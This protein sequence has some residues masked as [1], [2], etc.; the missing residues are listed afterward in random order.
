MISQPNT[1]RLRFQLIAVTFARLIISTAQRMFYPFLPEISRGLGVSQDTLRWMLSLRGAYGMSAPLFGPIV[2][3]FGRRNAMLIG[4]AIFCASLALV[5]IYPNVITVFLCI[6]LII[7]SKFVF[8]PAI[9]AYL[10]DH[11]P[12]EKRGLVIA[13]TEFG[14]AGA[15][16][17]GV[18]VVGF[19]IARGDWRAP[20]WPLAGLGVLAAIWMAAAI[21][22]DPPHPGHTGLNG[23]DRWLK[24]IRNPVVLAALITNML[25]AA[26]NEIINIVYGSWMEQTFNLRVVQLGLS[27]AVIGVA[28]LIAEGGVAV[29]S[30]RLGKRQTLILGLVVS[31]V[32][33]FLLPFGS[34][35]LEWA[36]AGIFAVYLAFEFAIVASIPLI[37]ELMPEYRNTVMSTSIAA[38]AAGRMIGSLLGGFVFQ[39]GFLW[40]GVVAGILTMIGIPLILWVVRE[41]Q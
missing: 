33:Y 21:P 1:S 5:A 35:S 36:L 40:N 24:V 27:V 2:D 30:D 25:S 23:L 7:T 20:F 3:R 22:P 4:M 18:P 15:V 8:D 14:W 28:E 16:L 19:L 6:L 12:Y 41:R 13:L 26:S 37:S 39:F 31:A 17:I 34:H 38:H 29:L 10:S 11:V 9:Q 32:S